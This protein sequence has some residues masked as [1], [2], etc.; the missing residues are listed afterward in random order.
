MLRATVRLAGWMRFLIVCSSVAVT[1]LAYADD[2]LPTKIGPQKRQWKPLYEL[3]PQSEKSAEQTNVYSVLQTVTLTELPIHGEL[4]RCWIASPRDATHQTLEDL[5]INECPGVWTIVQDAQ[6]RGDFLYLE[7][8]R[9]PASVVVKISFRVRRSPEFTNLEGLASG[10]LSDGLKSMLAEYL[11]KD[12]PHM[13]VT[14]EFQKIADTICGDETTIALQA[15][16]LLSHVASTLNHYSYAEDPNMPTCGVGDAAVCKQQGGGC[17]TDLNSYFIA[18]ARARGIP[19]KLN[20]GYRVQEKNSGHTI[21]PGYRCWVE[22]FVPGA[23]WVSADIVEADTPNGLGP[24]RWFE[25]LTSR[26]IWLNEGREFDFGNQ[27]AVGR[28]NH[29]SIGYAEV[30]GQPIRLLPHGDEKPQIARL[31]RCTEVQA[32]I[33]FEANEVE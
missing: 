33:K 5:A 10:P 19:A 13:E 17:C 14:E 12:A 4:L 6:R 31:I 3:F 11:V 20:M 18:L 29:M 16:M 2:G 7:V 8:K 30:D 28:V 21:D 27:L 22:Y 32:D 24:A 23:G 25:G 15:R 26:R 1:S 9:P